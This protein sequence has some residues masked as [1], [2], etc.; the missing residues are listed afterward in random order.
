MKKMVL[1]LCLMALS[2]GVVEVNAKPTMVQKIATGVGIGINRWKPYL[3][4]GPKREER[5]LTE[6]EKLIKEELGDDTPVELYLL[7]GLVGLAL[8]ATL[9]MLY[10]DGNN[11]TIGRVRKAWLG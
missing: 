3:T 2:M 4:T 8:T 6:E 9:A 1:L 10:W 11:L 5:V 7:G